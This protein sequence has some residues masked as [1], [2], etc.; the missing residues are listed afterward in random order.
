M[1]KPQYIDT[2]AQAIIDELVADYEGATGRVLQ[3]AQV[4]R[5]LIN[6]WAYREHLIRIGINEAANQNLVAF[7]K[8]PMIDNLGMLVGVYRLPASKAETI[9]KFSFVE[10]HGALVMPSGIRV[11]SQDGQA[12]FITTEEIVVSVNQDSVHVLAECTVDGSV[13]NGYLPGQVIVILD[14]QPYLSGATNLN[15]T[16]GGANEESD[17]ELRERI[18]LAPASFST[19]G[20]RGAYK[21]YAKSAHPGIIDVGINSPIPGQVNIYPLMFDGEPPAQA[22]L[23]AVS[24]ICNDEKIRPLTDTVIVDAP[25]VI[26]YAIEVEL[27]LLTDAIPTPVVNE[28]TAALQ[29]YADDRKKKLGLNV[30]NT[31]IIARSNV[32]NVYSVSVVSPSADIVIDE[33]QYA[34]CTS[35]TINI[36]GFNDE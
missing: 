9:I 26:E 33:N 36:A 21:Y 15:E 5:L 20:P 1:D 19:A 16:G 17:D 8:A 24:A 13:G 25:E 11:Q 31:Q 10:G 12:V 2:D 32:Q 4:E 27:T 14:P 6:T 35:I 3:P 23:D 7:S 34:K 22:V 18:K 30:V 28:V 29:K